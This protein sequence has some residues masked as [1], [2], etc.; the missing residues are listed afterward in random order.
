MFKKF[1]SAV[2]L[3]CPLILQGQW[4]EEP[5]CEEPCC[6]AR[7]NYH[8]F[9]VGPEYTYLRLHVHETPTEPELTFH[10]NLWGIVGAYEYKIPKGFYFNFNAVYRKNPITGHNE[11]DH[12]R[13][14]REQNLEGRVGYQFVFGCC[15]QWKIIP[16]TGFAWN[17]IKQS[18]IAPLNNRL[19]AVTYYIPVGF[20]ATYSYNENFIIGFHAKYQ[21]QV[22]ASVQ[23]KT[24]KPGRWDIR[25]EDGWTLEWPLIYQFKY[26]IDGSITLSPYWRI[27]RK[28]HG[29]AR[30]EVGVK[31]PIAAQVFHYGGVKLLFGI[32]F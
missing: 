9:D 19:R 17:C 25:N 6:E 30:S 13:H 23:I 2:F 18:D 5:C 26:C 11:V 4:C 3:F 10:G 24:I 7:P 16:Y 20:I 8:H 32:N 22:D 31:V 29:T 1:L 21:P 12:Y 14:Y 28:G 15:D 27:L